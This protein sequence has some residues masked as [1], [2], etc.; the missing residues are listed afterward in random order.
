MVGTVQAADHIHQR[1]LARTVGAD[2]RADLAACNR[3][4]HARERHHAA[5]GQADTL[6]LQH[7]L[8]GRRMIQGPRNLRARS[9]RGQLA[10]RLQPARRIE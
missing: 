5:K 4:I 9:L 1:A 3:Q 10:Q 7:R 6:Q 2:D 8:H